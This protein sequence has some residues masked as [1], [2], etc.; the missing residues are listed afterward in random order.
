MG[1]EGKGVILEWHMGALDFQRYHHLLIIVDDL[2]LY[3]T[4]SPT[5][6]DLKLLISAFYQLYGNWRSYI[7]QKSDKDKTG[8][9]TKRDELL[10]KLRKIENEI[11][12]LEKKT[13]T[14]LAITL[15][16]E[17]IK[18]I[19]EFHWELMYIKDNI[20]MSVPK[21]TV[22]GLKAEIEDS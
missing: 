6:E 2:M 9:S 13:T 19:R 7:Q 22:R 15:N 4:E 3:L 16:S 10:G 8:Y 12:Q 21:R 17:L 14:K 11:Y 20:G 18:K 1:E 5:I